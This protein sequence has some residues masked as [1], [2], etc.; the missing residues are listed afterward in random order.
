MSPQ[1]THPVTAEAS[2]M[3]LTVKT[4][5]ADEMAA[6]SDHCSVARSRMPVLVPLAE[7][8]IVFWH[9]TICACLFSASCLL[10]K[11]L[12]YRLAFSGRF[13]PS[14]PP[15]NQFCYLCFPPTFCR[16][17][18]LLFRCARLLGE[19]QDLTPS[20]SEAAFLAM[21]SRLL[22]CSWQFFCF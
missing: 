6:S 3:V 10:G 13:F 7:R 19:W 4:H 9:P 8:S 14:F 22:R 11:R 20:V 15:V 17:H 2:F 21:A 12:I 18:D 1:Q 16:S 5:L